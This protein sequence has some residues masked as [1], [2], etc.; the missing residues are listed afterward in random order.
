MLKLKVEVEHWKLKAYDE[1]VNNS[2]Q[3]ERSQPT[4]VSRAL[5]EVLMQLPSSSFDANLAANSMVS[6]SLQGECAASHHCTAPSV[7]LYS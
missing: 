1:Y 5:P 4:V 2:M 7:C 6:E 3:V